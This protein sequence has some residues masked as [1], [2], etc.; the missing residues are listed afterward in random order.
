MDVLKNR[1]LDLNLA[2]HRNKAWM[3]SKVEVPFQ[4]KKEILSSIFIENENA[5]VFYSILE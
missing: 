2:R 3:S 1:D 4:K 5:T